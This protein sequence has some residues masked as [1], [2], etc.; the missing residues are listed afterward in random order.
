MAGTYTSSSHSSSFNSAKTT[1]DTAHHHQHYKRSSPTADNYPPL[2]GDEQSLHNINPWLSATDVSAASAVSCPRSSSVHLCPPPC[3]SPSLSSTKN[4][5]KK[6]DSNSTQCLD[7]LQVLHI[8]EVCGSKKYPD[9]KSRRA[10]LRGLRMRHCCEH[11]VDSALP[12][13]T[14]EGGSICKQHLDA[15]LQIDQITS[16]LTCN[17]ADLLIR[18]D[19]SQNFS[20][21]HDCKDCKVIFI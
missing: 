16:R 13:A 17:H 20:I 1:F 9:S 5:N 19:C 3:I 10:K 6:I 2:S 11:A 4:N 8:E 21:A 14:F 15:L 18:Y 7:Y 12:E